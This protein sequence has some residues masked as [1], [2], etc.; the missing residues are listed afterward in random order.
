MLLNWASSQ[1]MLHQDGQPDEEFGMR[2]SPP[3]FCSDRLLSDTEILTATREE[4]LRRRSEAL[5]ALEKAEAQG[6]REGVAQARKQ[7]RQAQVLIERRQ[8]E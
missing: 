2:R 1:L 4:I 3:T 5:R 7:V 6:D 8:L